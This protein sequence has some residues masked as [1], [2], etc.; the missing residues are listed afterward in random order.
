MKTEHPS[1][2]RLI[3]RREFLIREFI[4]AM[5]LTVILL[6]LALAMPASYTPEPENPVSCDIRA[7]WLIIWL[8]V[9]LR[10]FPPFFA[11]IIV[12]L[13]ACS[14]LTLLPWFPHQSDRDPAKRY[15]FGLP[16]AILAAMACTLIGLTFWGL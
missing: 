2:A 7:P 5:A 6:I 1:N 14:I 3:V 9:L 16:Q 4:A 13:T 10:W 8:Q 11:G 15:H 12:P